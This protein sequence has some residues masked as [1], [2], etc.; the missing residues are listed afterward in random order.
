MDG[1][2]KGERAGV[3]AG[4][5]LLVVIMVIGVLAAGTSPAVA[6]TSPAVA[7]TSPAGAEPNLRPGIARESLFQITGELTATA[8]LPLIL[9]P[10]PL[11]ALP[12]FVLR[13]T[14]EGGINASTYSS[15]S[16][17]LTNS[18][19]N[20]ENVTQVRLDLSTS[21]FM[22]M[23][24][25]P[26]GQA[27]D[28][29]AK[30]FT[31]DLDPGVGFAGRSYEGFHDDGFDILTVNFTD[32][33]PGE[34]FDFSVDVD[35][36]SIRGVPAP[37]PGESGS[38]SG[39]ELSGATVT[40][41]YAGGGMVTGQMIRMPG[42]NSGSQLFLRPGLAA[43]PTVEVVGVAGNMATVA[44]PNQVLRVSGPAGQRVHVIIVQGALF[45][46]GLPGGGFDIDPFESNS[47]LEPGLQSLT[48]YMA[49]TTIDIPI[50]LT[51]TQVEGG[52]NNILVF[53]SDTYDFTGLAAPPI[54]LELQN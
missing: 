5:C 33:N 30:D 6:G 37:G 20:S 24:Y 27:G 48:A 47:V 29:V 32:F 8:L 19:G 18:A 17:Q 9:N 3:V 25:D 46:Q 7:G 49:G 42:S 11:P 34:Q 53:F 41:T 38:V 13:I 12:E 43:A 28:F 52:W 39:L 1:R 50:T 54:V 15:H 40:V 44:D 22:D 10:P 26:N 4:L 16:F 31:I 45:T 36:T 51:R 2:D 23:V 21:F 35:P 14:P